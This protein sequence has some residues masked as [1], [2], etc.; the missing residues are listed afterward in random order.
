ML[1]RRARKTDLSAIDVMMARAYGP[2]MAAS[3]PPSLLILAVPF[4]TRAQ[5]ALVASGRYS[6]AEDE[7]GRILG[8]GGWSL[9][10]AGRGT[11]APGRA[12]VRH[13]AVDAAAA[14]Q[15]VGRAL[16]QRSF[17]EAAAAG[18]TW[19]HCTATLNAVPFYERLD[20][21]PIGPVTVPLAPA[22]ALPALAMWRDL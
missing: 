4:I 11:T 16:M 10:R 8:A 3:Y 20:F 14:G 9:A 7:A 18:A 13:L 22:I 1:I 6:V 21:T 2:Q 17:A 5:P 19:L 12:D 15:G